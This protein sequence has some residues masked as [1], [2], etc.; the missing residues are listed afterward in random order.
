MED[1]RWRMAEMKIRN[2][3]LRNLSIRK[4]VPVLVISEFLSLV[5]VS[6][7][8]I[9]IS[10]FP[11]GLHFLQHHILER[12]LPHVAFGEAHFD[13]AIRRACGSAEWHEYRCPAGSLLPELR[14]AGALVV[15][16][17]A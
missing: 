13:L 12:C 16:G 15:I 6:N 2:P 17:V 14:P 3:N 9:R 8:E 7:F 5:L 10:D 11:S 4:A 1:R